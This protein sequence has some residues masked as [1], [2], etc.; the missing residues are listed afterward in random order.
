MGWF[1]YNL[2][3]KIQVPQEKIEEFCKKYFIIK[4]SFFGSVLRDDFHENSDI[5]VL[6]EFDKEHSP[7]LIRFAGMEIELTNLFNKKVDLR[8][9]GDLSRYFRDEVVRNAKPFYVQR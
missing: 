8:S 7:G 1:G 3:M 5:D 6:V 4:L 2:D 9:P